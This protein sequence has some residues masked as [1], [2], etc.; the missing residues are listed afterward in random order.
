MKKICKECKKKLPAN[1]SY[2]GYHIKSKKT[3]RAK[4]KECVK[5]Y[6]KKYT[7]TDKYK[8]K[9]RLS[10][11]K[12]RKENPLR[13]KEISNR[14]RNKNK[15]KINKKAR[16]KYLNDPF[17]KQKLLDIE[18]KYKDSGRRKEVQSTPECLEKSRVR[19]ANRRKNKE[20]REKDNLRSEIYR[21]ENKDKLNK[22]HFENRLNLIPSYVAQTM[23]VSVKDLTPE[24]YETKKL[25]IELK[26]ELKNNNVKIR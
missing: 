18:K 11:I 22:M 3:L 21:K 1:N 4:C 19:S 16:Y 17:Y 9:H 7:S 25:I 15:E 14:S 8:E 12:Y 5:I 2:F 20:Y 23:R 10:M 24:I 13:S 6:R 26:R